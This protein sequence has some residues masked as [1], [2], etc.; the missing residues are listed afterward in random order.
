MVTIK[1]NNSTVCDS[2]FIF[3]LRFP[4]QTSDNMAEF[5]SNSM[6]VYGCPSKFEKNWKR[7]FTT[8]IYNSEQGTTEWILENSNNFLIGTQDTFLYTTWNQPYLHWHG[9][10]KALKLFQTTLV[11]L[12]S[13][14]IMW[15]PII[16]RNVMCMFDGNTLCIVPSLINHINNKLF[17]L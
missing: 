17:S 16:C 10:G 15:N 12:Y 11:F 7:L 4:K 14:S 6:Y 3:F 13:L 2:S 5:R 9:A 8:K 1:N